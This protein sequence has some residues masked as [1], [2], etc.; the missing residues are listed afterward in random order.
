MQDKIPKP[1]AS[2]DKSSVL[3]NVGAYAS[4]IDLPASNEN[5]VYP[6]YP[7]LIPSCVCIEV[8]RISLPCLFTFSWHN[9]L[10]QCELL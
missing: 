9:L 5:Q 6:H 1:S 3:K 2:G 7:L 4:S 8:L 10:S